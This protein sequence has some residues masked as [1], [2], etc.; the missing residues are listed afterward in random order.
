MEDWHGDHGFEPSIAAQVTNAIPPYVLKTEA[1][2]FSPFS[3]TAPVSWDHVKQMERF[4]DEREY[5]E[6]EGGNAAGKDEACASQITEAKGPDNVLRAGFSSMEWI[7]LGLGRYARW[8][9]SQGIIPTD[10]M[11]Q[12]EARRLIY[13]SEDG[14][15]QTIAD[16]GQW[17][18]SF[19]SEH[20]DDAT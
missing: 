17:L 10:E 12:N 9:M 18:A 11:F 1:K 7:T 4:F 6:G 8:Q 5:G 15:E 19:R 20:V 14:W 2:S 3:A 16:N 13:G